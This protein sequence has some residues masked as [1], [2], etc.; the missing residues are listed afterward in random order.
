VRE[1][2][3]RRGLRVRVPGGAGMFAKVLEKEGL[4]SGRR[5]RY[6]GDGGRI[7]EGGRRGDCEWRQQAAQP[8][9]VMGGVGRMVYTGIKKE[10]GSGGVGCGP[11]RECACG[12]SL[13]CRNGR[14]LGG[15]QIVGL[16]GG[17]RA[18]THL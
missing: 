1:A 14:R 15:P 18:G 12:M 8:K 7:E 13:S 10:D 11:R 6:T 5:R 3:R 9:T 4:E 2:H 17:T 16:K